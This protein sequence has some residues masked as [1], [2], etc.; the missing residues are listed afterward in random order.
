MRKSLVILLFIIGCAS[1]LPV[2]YYIISFSSRHYI[3]NNFANLSQYRNVLVFGSGRIYAS[4]HPNYA[5]TGRIDA[6]EKL[7]ELPSVSKIILS[8]RNDAP[9]YNEV[10]EMKKELMERNV[11]EKKIICDSNG[12]NTLQSLINY[13][14]AYG[15]Q[16]VILVSQKEHLERAL[17]YAE[18]LQI[19]ASGYIA[20]GNPETTFSFREMA[21]RLK[22]RIEMIIQ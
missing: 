10:E 4:D 1:V 12:T 20:E 13:R 17:Y 9:H 21:A 2:N 15:K 3:F 6:V 16:P 8:G 14:H 11:T 18:K 19:S 7:N 22:A 5:F